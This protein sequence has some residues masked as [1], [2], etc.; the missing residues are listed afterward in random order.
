MKKVLSVT[1]V[2]EDP[3]SIP[4]GHA[5]RKNSS[6]EG[7]TPSATYAEEYNS[8]DLD[9]SRSDVRLDETFVNC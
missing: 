2:K 6:D 4:R 8:L 7:V 3:L 5:T 1:F 9:L